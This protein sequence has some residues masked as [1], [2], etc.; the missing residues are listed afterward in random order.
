MGSQQIELQQ[1][2]K[3]A[4]QETQHHPSFSRRTVMAGVGLFG[5]ALAA[6]SDKAWAQGA[7]QFRPKK[8]IPLR[9]TI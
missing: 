9:S 1:A 6:L 5:A 4:A 7:G 8:D 2:E 3:S